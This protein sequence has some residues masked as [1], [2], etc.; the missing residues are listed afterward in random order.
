MMENSRNFIPFQENT[1]IITLIPLVSHFLPD[2]HSQA[3]SYGKPEC[4]LLLQLINSVSWLEKARGDRTQYQRFRGG[5]FVSKARD[6]Q[7]VCCQR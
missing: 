7:A 2:L 5:S 6:F 4:S 3:T 1:V